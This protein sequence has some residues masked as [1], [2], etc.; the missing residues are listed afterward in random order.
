MAEIT[1]AQKIKDKLSINTPDGDDVIDGLITGAI[2]HIRNIVTRGLDESGTHTEYFDEGPV[3]LNQTPVTSITTIRY[4]DGTEYITETDT[5]LW[6]LLSTGK[7]AYSFLEGLD[8]LEVEYVG[9]GQEEVL[10]ELIER[11]VIRQYRKLEHE[12]EKSTSFEA[13]TT[14]WHEVLLDSDWDILDNYRVCL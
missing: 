8:A 14:S 6:R 5:T 7:L 11:I 10:R 12:G 4:W 13:S 9:G 3:Y 1:T 2:A